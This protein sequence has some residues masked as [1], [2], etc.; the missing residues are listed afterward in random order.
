MIDVASGGRSD[1]FLPTAPLFIL[2]VVLAV[3]RQGRHPVAG[4]QEGWTERERETEASEREEGV[5][6]GDLH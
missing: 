1:G 4:R 6:T 3:R 2:I 5:D